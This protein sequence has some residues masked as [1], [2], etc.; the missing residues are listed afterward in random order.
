MLPTSVIGLFCEDIRAEKSGTE[1]LVGIMPTNTSA[2][3]FPAHAPKMALYV[4]INFDPSQDP[5][6]ISS[7]LVFPGGEEEVLGVVGQH[8]VDE[9]RTNAIRDNQPI[10][11]L[12]SR[13]VMGVQLKQ[14]GQLIAMVTVGAQEFVAAILDIREQDGANASNATPQPSEQSPGASPP[15]AS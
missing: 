14:A 4:R 3:K 15:I 7:K 8:I 1:S 6:P 2:A 12:V 13:A 5:G 9:A 11:G 10:A